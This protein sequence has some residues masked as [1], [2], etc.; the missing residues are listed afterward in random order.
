MKSLSRIKPSALIVVILAA[1]QMT[2][3][4]QTNRPPNA[5][6]DAEITNPGTAIAISVLAN[7]SDPQ[8]KALKV[9][10]VSAPANGTATFN[11]STVIYAPNSGFT[12]IDV[13]TYVISNGALTDTAF[14]DAIV[15]PP[16]DSI[17]ENDI[18]D[19]L[20]LGALSGQNG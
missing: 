15:L 18:F 16:P 6:D 13:F 8:G 9:I 19:P 14:V 2:A 5:V 12:D 1:L 11:D 10:A 17:W 7:D 4:A 20:A 3:V